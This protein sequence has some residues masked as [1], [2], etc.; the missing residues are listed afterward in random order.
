M[1]KTFIICLDGLG[2]KEVCKNKTP[3]LYK[4]SKKNSL[5][6][7]KTLL[8]FTGIPSSFFSGKYPKDHN[9]WFEFK[10]SP[11]TSPFRWQKYFFFLGRKMLSYL[12]ALKLYLSGRNFLTKLY[13]IPYKYMKYFDAGT[14]KNIW[15]FEPI[16]NKKYFCYKWPFLAKYNKIKLKLK[17]ESDLERCN[18]L[19]KNISDKIDIYTVQLVGLDKIAHMYG[20]KH[21]E[22]I[23]KIKQLDLIME[24]LIPIL[25]KRIPHSNIIL[26]SDHGFLDIKKEIN[27]QEMLPKSKDYL[28]FYAGTT[29]SFWFKHDE[30]KK[31][32][33]NLLSKIKE[34]H[35]L[36]EKGRKKYKIPLSKEHGE[37]IFVMNP[38]NY[39]FP[40]FYQHEKPFKAMHGYAPN[41]ADSDGILII[42]KK[43]KKKTLN[44]IDVCKLF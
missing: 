20:T 34:G 11:K 28:A 31:E 36:T 22:Y 15:Q 7:L 17:Y 10:Y 40:N 2:Y 26:W 18:T 21:P 1:K 4:F 39:I 24:K 33:I 13:N 37:I 5:I 41:E 43:I 27:L 16:K 23:K 19:L 30:I 29:T 44:M 25:K 35:I 6:R 12:T 8:A 32:I 38:G 14:T 42:N 9:I 3:F